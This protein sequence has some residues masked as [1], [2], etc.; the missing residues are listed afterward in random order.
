MEPLGGRE[1]RDA[2]LELAEKLS[3]RGVHGRLYI[4]GGAAMAMAHDTEKHT[5]DIDAAILEGHGAVITAVR[6]IARERHWPSTWLNE[7]ATGY[8]PAVPDPHGRVVLDHPALKVVVASREHMLAMKVRAAR[9]ADVDDTRR[10]LRD[11]DL[12][13]V[14][15][16]EALV[17][18]VF[19][20][21]PLGHRQREWL[22]Q[23][24]AATWA[25][26]DEDPAP[27]ADRLDS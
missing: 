5:R 22:E 4:A 17:E 9:I 3:R 15:Q 26:A 8:M 2:L 11:L 23:L 14:E 10:L 25:S 7:Q 18:S 19:P 27:D 24:C 13:R 12:R 20:A 1:I 6:E 21:E 16:V